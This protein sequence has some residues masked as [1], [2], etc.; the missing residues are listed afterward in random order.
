M[1]TASSAGSPSPVARLA[2][3]FAARTRAGRL[4]TSSVALLAAAVV[5][6]T[7]V[8]RNA[9]LFTTPIYEDGD[10]ALNS[11]LAERAAHLQLT[12]GNYSRVGFHH[13]GPALLYLLAAGQAV[14]SGLLHVVP[15]PYNGQLLGVFVAEA[16]MLGLVIGIIHRVTGSA[17]ASV[18]CVGV[19]VLFA[20]SQPML[21]SVWFPYLY[22]CPFLLLM[23]SGAAVGTGRTRELPSF[24]LAAG[25]LV[26]GHVS[27]ISVVGATAVLTGIGWCLSH[28]G[29]R[30]AEVAVHG[31]SVVIAVVVVVAFATPMVVQTLTAWPGPWRDYW[32]YATGS[33]GPA[34]VHGLRVSW[35]YL[36]WYWTR[37]RAWVPAVV[38][39]AAVGA[40]VTAR[41]RNVARHRF[42]A[43]IYVMALL[44]TGLFW[45][46]LARGVDVLD[47]T[48]R[49]TGLF[50]FTVP[51]LVA[52]C[53]AAQAVTALRRRSGV[54]VSVVGLAAV[55]ALLFGAA[56]S[57][58]A[59][60][61]RGDK[62]AHSLVAAIAADPQRA[63]REVELSGLPTAW[64]QLA[65][66]Q[67][68]ADRRHLAACIQDRRFTNLFTGHWI[69]S[70]AH[71]WTVSIITTATWNGRGTLIERR[72]ELLAVTGDV[73]GRVRSGQ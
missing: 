36:G 5:L 65:A 7:L 26:H 38:V 17:V 72:G 28:R 18:A 69:C 4:S 14:F 51:L 27:F 68:A 42:F 48:N 60:R 46:Y 23:V 52:L 10:P 62:G 55:A 20:G 12:V 2:L 11:L 50:Y 31:R 15:T 22:L 73:S 40:A 35:D 41:D 58:T 19:L 1:S 64:P 44:Q 57:G 39:A 56:G 37:H 25:L 32:A 6:G 49:Y 70:G 30:R 9:Y 67:L 66:V 53:G 33:K 59:S 21:A 16:A 47:A 61:Y 13:P 8:V 45:F 29:G 43:A 63:G 54:T 34:H 71:T 3:R 24:V